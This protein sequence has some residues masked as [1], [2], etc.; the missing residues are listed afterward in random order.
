MYDKKK[1]S[2][3]KQIGRAI[4]ISHMVIIDA[5]LLKRLFLINKPHSRKYLKSG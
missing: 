4:N 1:F 5:T 3:Q 2:V